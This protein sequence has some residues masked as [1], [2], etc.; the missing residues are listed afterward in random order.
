MDL[1]ADMLVKHAPQGTPIDVF[2]PKYQKILGLVPSKMA[3]NFDRWYNRWKVYP[4]EVVKLPKKTGFFHI[5]DHSYA[6]LANHLPKGRVGVYC[7]DLDAFRCILKPETEKRPEW[8]RKMMGR[9]FDGLIRAR[10]I[11]CSTAITKKNLLDLGHWEHE[12]IHVVPY[13]IAE[14]F[15]VDGNRE[16]GE[17]ILHVGSCIQ[18]KRIDVLIEAFGLLSK[19]NSKLKLIQAGGNFSGEQKKQIQNLNLEARVEQ[20]QN[21]TRDDLARLYRGARTLVIT[22]DAE[23]FGLPV[24]ESLACGTTV[25]ASDLPEI[26]EAGGKL[27]SYFPKGN[28]GSCADAVQ[29][30]LENPCPKQL[31]GFQEKWSWKVFS[32]AICNVYSNMK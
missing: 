25:V 12:S 15:R 4:K 14:E 23:G 29:A 6:H 1:C 27:V 3:R 2:L 10:L 26:M 32:A 19:K 30:V 17:Y 20:R 5:M 18:R 8:F 24:I 9:V 13:G 22:S 7:H 11:F 16:S 28:V 31:L 21:L